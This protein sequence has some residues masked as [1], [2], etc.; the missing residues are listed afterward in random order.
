MEKLFER[1]AYGKFYGLC[2]L[3]IRAALFPLY[4]TSIIYR[5]VIQ[6]RGELYRLGILT[7]EKVDLKVISVGNISVGGTG[8][9]PTTEWLAGQLNKRGYKIAILSRGYGGKRSEKFGTVSKGDSALM[10][11]SEA[12][13][14]PYMLAKKLKGVAVFVGPDRL[15]LAKYAQNKYA[16][17]AVI[18]D[19]GFQHI[20]LKRDVNILLFD[21]EKGVGNGNLLPRGPL[22]EPM[23]AAGRADIVLINKDGIEISNLIKIVEKNAPLAPV[24]RTNYK[25]TQLKKLG[26]DETETLGSLSAMKVVLISGIANPGSFS[27]LV[28]S[29]GA[30]IVGMASFPDHHEYKAEDMDKVFSLAEGLSANAIITTEKDAVKLEAMDYCTETPI[31]TM[32]IGLEFKEDPDRLIDLIIEKAGLSEKKDKIYP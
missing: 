26:T 28:E 4:L 19:D 31:Y 21:G 5:I 18:L 13:D 27:K 8:K 1:I 10:S 23:R 3:L 24:F 25:A 22:R 30:A 6:T 2:G 11:P 17:D 9:T 20:R 32:E 29:M 14:E 15:K 12:G 7:S 16:L